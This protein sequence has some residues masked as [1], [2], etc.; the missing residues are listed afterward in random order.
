MSALVASR[1]RRRAVESASRGERLLLLQPE[2]HTLVHLETYMHAHSV[3][4]D[5]R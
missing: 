1:R 2:Q 4:L 3:Y 5:S